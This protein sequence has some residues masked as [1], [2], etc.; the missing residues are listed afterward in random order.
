M[1]KN[2]CQTWPRGPSGS[3]CPA[4]PTCP[5]SPW[6]PPRTWWCRRCFFG[7]LCSFAIFWPIPTTY[8][9]TKQ[10]NNHVSIVRKSKIYLYCSYI[11]DAWE[12]P[13]E[14]SCWDPTK[15]PE[16]KKSLWTFAIKFFKKFT[17]ESRPDYPPSSFR[18][19]LKI[20]KT[21][22]LLQNFWIITLIRSWYEIFNSV[23]KL[24]SLRR[25]LKLFLKCSKWDGS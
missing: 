13:L 16:K 9:W 23:T 11:E 14:T 22:Y 5:C 10:E 3:W 17:R 18:F 24:P 7:S 19:S 20:G 4:S 2:V 1:D 25:D 8:R 12:L 6:S 21:I 15:F